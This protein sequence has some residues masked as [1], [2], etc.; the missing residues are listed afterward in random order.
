M[1]LTY[2]RPKQSDNPTLSPNNVESF[3]VE[4]D[5]LGNSENIA[6]IQYNIVS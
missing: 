3:W 6:A 4:H 5:K 1:L 2:S